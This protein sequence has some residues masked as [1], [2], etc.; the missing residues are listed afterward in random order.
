MNIDSM[1]YKQKYLFKSIN[2][3]EKELKIHHTF[4][5]KHLEKGTIYKGKNGRKFI[6][7][8]ETDSDKSND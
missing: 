7:K 2:Q 6:F 3:A 1:K 8:L 5:S 4:I